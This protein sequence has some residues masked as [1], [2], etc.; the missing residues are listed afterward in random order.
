MVFDRV[1]DHNYVEK[2]VP[3]HV[4]HDD[5]APR[6]MALMGLFERFAQKATKV[7]RQFCSDA[8]TPRQCGRV[9]RPLALAMEK[10]R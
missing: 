5:W 7:D 6:E 9:F 2:K 4:V 1:V 8:H 10:A 3:P